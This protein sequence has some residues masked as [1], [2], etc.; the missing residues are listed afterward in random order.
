MPSR[1]SS[2]LLGVLFGFVCVFP[3]LVK[4]EK[5]VLVL[6]SE[7]LLHQAQAQMR[8]ARSKNRE[9]AVQADGEGRSRRV[10]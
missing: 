3:L 2:S 5:K 7:V 6:S 10:P 1:F 8:E 4:R 9:R